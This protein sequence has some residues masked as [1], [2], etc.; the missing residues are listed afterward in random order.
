MA[1]TIK[2]INENAYNVFILP[3]A[4][5]KMELYC[6][7]C[8]KEIGGLGFVNHFGIVEI[9]SSGEE[10]LCKAPHFLLR[11]HVA[12]VIVLGQFSLDYLE[13]LNAH[14]VPL[15]CVDFSYSLPDEDAIVQ[16]NITGGFLATELLIK[17][18]HNKIAYVGSIHQTTSI[19][20]RYLGYHKALIQYGL[21]DH[22]EALIEDRDGAG[23]YID[24]KLPEDMP[25]A[26]FCN[27]D[28]TA[29]MLM[30]DLQ[31]KGIRVP[32]DMSIVGFDDSIY[33]E[34][35]TPQLTTVAVDREGMCEF[36]VRDILRK[37]ELRG[38][39]DEWQSL[40]K[41]VKVSLNERDSVGPPRA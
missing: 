33:A 22:Y 23:I 13:M 34:M 4:R 17:N 37:I 12:G 6:A 36:T 19:M 30:K 41:V 20:D 14:Q 27:S 28:E 9:I 26:L 10:K 11:D 8:E 39:D 5:T 38:N 29:Y 18:G 15:I 16:D 25:T 21:A 1:K 24:M 3:Q 35:T 2:L 40:R 31:V 32:E 7:L